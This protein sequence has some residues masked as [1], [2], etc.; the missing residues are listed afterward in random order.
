M[1]SLFKDR[2]LKGSEASGFAQGLKFG[3]EEQNLETGTWSQGEGSRNRILTDLEGSL[4][5]LDIG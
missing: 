5:P 1:A 4:R 2:S 3:D